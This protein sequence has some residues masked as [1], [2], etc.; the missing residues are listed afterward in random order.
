MP[1]VYIAHYGHPLLKGAKHWAILVSSGPK[2][3]IAYQITGSTHTYEVKPPEES[4]PETSN[5]YMGMVEVGRIEE[6]QRQA[7]ERI[8]LANPVT[9]GSVSWNCQNWVIEVLSAAKAAGLGI[10]AY[11]LQELQGRLAEA[12][13]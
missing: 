5:T 1:A 6:N 12:T 10:A 9:R 13:K 4:R 3:F 7:F 11:S 2:D 8:A